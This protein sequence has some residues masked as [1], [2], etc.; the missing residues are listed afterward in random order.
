MTSKDSTMYNSCTNYSKKAQIMQ[1]KLL[2]WKNK[3][4]WTKN[5]V[6]FSVGTNISPR[7]DLGFGNSFLDWLAFGHPFTHPRQ[8]K[9]EEEPEKKDNGDNLRNYVFSSSNLF[10]VHMKAPVLE[11]LLNKIADFQSATLLK[12]RLRHKWRVC[13]YTGALVL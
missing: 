9:S 2:N 6:I 10:K 1:E 12:K 8:K 13:H 7:H 4:C 3:F 11:C 5:R